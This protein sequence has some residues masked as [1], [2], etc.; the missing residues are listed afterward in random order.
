MAEKSKD[1]R[2]GILA[3]KALLT[4]EPVGEWHLVIGNPFNPIAMIGNL[5]CEDV[6]YSFGGGDE[7]LGPDDFPETLNISVSLKHGRPRDKGD[8]ESM[9][10]RGQGRL[11]YSYYGKEEPWNSTQATKNVAIMKAATTYEDNFDGKT[12]SIS[13]KLSQNDYKTLG[14]ETGNLRTSTA[15]VMGAT[16]KQAYD[17]A[18][19]V[20][21]KSGS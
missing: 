6:S 15:N 8:I 16:S 10:N 7:R 3:F 11:H 5:I 21:Y 13:G 2:P 14:Q 19:K 4:G 1:K 17:L 9:F 18:A 12:H 20:G